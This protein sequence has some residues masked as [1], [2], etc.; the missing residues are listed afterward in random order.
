MNGALLRQVKKL[1]I[2]R[3]HLLFLEFCD[4]VILSVLEEKVIVSLFLGQ[5]LRFSFIGEI[6]IGSHSTPF[7]SPVPQK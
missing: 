7:L 3:H 4:H 6:F 5:M 1:T 2:F